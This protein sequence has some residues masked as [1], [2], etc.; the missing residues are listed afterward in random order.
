MMAQQS[1]DKISVRSEDEIGRKIDRCLADGLLKTGGGLGI[2]IIF[3]VLLFKST[4]DYIF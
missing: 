3:S 1:G 2:G 4:S